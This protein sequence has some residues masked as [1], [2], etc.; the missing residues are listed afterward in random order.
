MPWRSELIST[1][2]ILHLFLLIDCLSLSLSSLPLIVSTFHAPSDLCSVV[3]KEVEIWKSS[4]VGY[5]S[6]S[7]ENEVKELESCLKKL[8]GMR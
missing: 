3:S 8:Q 4:G 5:F 6:D 7:S 1:L 2:M